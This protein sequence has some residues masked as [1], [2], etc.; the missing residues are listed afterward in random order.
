MKRNEEPYKHNIIMALQKILYK[1]TATV[2]EVYCV[3]VYLDN[4]KKNK[5]KLVKKWK[6][7]RHTALQTVKRLL[8]HL[9]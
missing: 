6:E 9:V 1:H 4:E 8:K 7:K 2:V 3:Y 5:I